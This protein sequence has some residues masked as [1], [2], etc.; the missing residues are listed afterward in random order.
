MPFWPGC[1]HKKL[2]F[3]MTRP[4]KVAQGSRRKNTYAVCLDCAKEIP[5]SWSEMRL[6]KERRQA[7]D[8]SH[9]RRQPGGL[10]VA[11][12]DPAKTKN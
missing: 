6:V 5:Y 9:S 7:D 10:Q 2:S 8:D 3:P 12:F 4:R 1:S 11:S